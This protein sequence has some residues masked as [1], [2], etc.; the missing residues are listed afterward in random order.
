MT[1]S[2]SLP[3]D[4]GSTWRGADMADPTAWTVSL[5][6]AERDEVVAAAERAAREGLTPSTLTRGAFPLAGMSATLARCADDLRSAR[7]FVLLRGFPLDRLT[8]ATTQLAYIGLGLHFGNP[9]CLDPTGAFLN[10]IRDARVLRSGPGV[11]ISQ[12]NLRQDFHTDQV[13][14]VGLLCL[15]PAKSGGQSRLVSAHAVYNEMLALRPDLVE[16]LYQPFWWDRNDE[17]PPGEAPTY[18][19]SV[20]TNVG[21]SPRFFYIGWYIRD[22]QRHQ[23]T[24]RLSAAQSEAIDLLEAIA[25]KPELCVGMDF[26]RGDV[27]LINDARIIHSREAYEDYDDPE[28]RRHLLRLLLRHTAE[29]QA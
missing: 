6:D 11:R 22:A 21:G 14:T 28:R 8:P 1:I 18:P 16:A 10:D 7:G 29:G 12:T 26:E 5:S 2:P 4:V 24:P 3:V 27:Q 17:Q 25:N 13:D 19:L 23:E 20:L 9:V 15:Q